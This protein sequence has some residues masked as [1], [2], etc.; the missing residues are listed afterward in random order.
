M[1]SFLLL[2][3]LNLFF[4]TSVLANQRAA[5]AM[6]DNYSTEVAQSVIDAGGNAID[7]AIAASFSL[8]VTYPEAGNLGG[9]GFMLIHHQ[10]ETQ[11]LDFRETAPQAAHRDL[12]LDDKGEVIPYKSL[13]GYQA[14]GVPGTVMGLWQ[15]H[16]T[17]G[18]LAW[19]EL[20]EPA[21]A[22]AEKGFIVHPKLA[23]T[24]D[25]YQAWS[26]D[27]SDQLNFSDYFA[28]LQAGET[29]QQPELAATLRRI[30]DEGAADFYQGE[31]A[32]LIAKQ[33]AK[34]DGLITRDDL[35]NYQARWREP[36]KG[37]WLGYDVYSAPPPS[38][39]G[40]ALIQ[41]LSMKNELAHE[42]EGL[43]HNSAEYIH[44]LAEI[45]KRVYAD[46]AEYLGD[47]DFVQVPI[48]QLLDP[49]Y[50]AQR[51]AEIDPMAISPTPQIQP[52]LVE[53]EQTTHFSILDHYGN[54]VSATIT[55][56]MPFG[57]GVVIEGAGFLMN[58]EM[59]DFSAKPGVPNVFGV[60][61]GEANAIAP[62]KRMLSSMTPTILL[63]NDQVAKV[64]GTPG[65]STIITSVFQSL[66]NYVEFSMSAQQAI[67]ANRIHHQLWPE[68]QIG[69]HPNLQAASIQDL[70][71]LGYQLESR[72]F[73]GD[74]Q[75]ITRSPI[76]ELQAASDHRG[77]GVSRVWQPEPTQ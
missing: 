6:P 17:Y 31:T 32:E 56:N 53:S 24:A 75:F 10:G 57:S 29:F 77:R 1:R 12:Y 67:D 55:L 25:W 76:G 19:S 2:I 42:F 60:V 46:R 51:S 3:S 39:G 41:L 21:I 13:L 45:M 40:I 14:S 71:N 58:D 36:V 23:E 5:V 74:L 26:Q 44:L 33:M 64:V 38:S 70:T 68:D 9:G 20:I 15:A 49:A 28:G 48:E 16:Q 52:G 59:D 8:A 35:A 43:F 69:Y 47:P 63:Q 4:Q 30:A 7:A 66:V 34:H 27:K 62:N 54:A 18:S 61:G 22:L 73:F 37:Q 65:G 50:L 72:R 11:F